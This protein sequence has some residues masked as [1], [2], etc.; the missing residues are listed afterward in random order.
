MAELP[1]APGGYDL[2]WSEGAIYN[3][4]FAPGLT[5]WRPLLAP[6]GVVAA[7]ECS[8]LTDTPDAGLRA[9]WDTAYPTMGTIEGNLAR[10]REAGYSPI[11]HFT[12]PADAWTVDYYDPIKAALPVLE[13]DHGDDPDIVAFIQEMKQEM[14]MFVEFGDQFGYVFYLGRIT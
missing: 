3:I 4:G 7:T 5:A 13:Q 2:I 10:M 1:L 8:W 12:L 9:F 14:R 6:G 11:G